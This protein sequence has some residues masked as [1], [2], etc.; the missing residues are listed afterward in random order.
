[1]SDCGPGR[2]PPRGGPV[3]SGAVA[4]IAAQRFRLPWICGR[5]MTDLVSHRP[6]GARCSASAKGSSPNRGGAGPRC[7]PPIARRGVAH[8]RVAVA[9]RHNCANPVRDAMLDVVDLALMLRTGGGPLGI[10]PS[11]VVGGVSRTGAVSAHGREPDCRPSP[12]RPRPHRQRSWSLDLSGGPPTSSLDP[13]RPSSRIHRRP[14]DRPV[15]IRSRAA[16]QED[17]DTAMSS[18]RGRCAIGADAAMASPKASRV[19]AIIFDGNGPG[20]TALTVMLRAELFGKHT[21]AGVARPCLAEY[22]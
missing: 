6:C 18:S 11:G 14:D 19:A 4:R 12:R 9:A 20:A 22:E 5:M 8:R 10:R 16:G 3:S 1:M 2:S 7:S 13:R 17:R 21:R 15:H